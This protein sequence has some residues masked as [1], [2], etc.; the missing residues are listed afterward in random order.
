[1]APKPRKEST[2][3][4]IQTTTG[5]SSA[6]TLSM[7]DGEPLPE[8]EI[9]DAALAELEREVEAEFNRVMVENVGGG[10]QA[11]AADEQPAIVIVPSPHTMFFHP[12][13][14]HPVLKHVNQHGAQ[15]G[16]GTGHP[17]DQQGLQQGVHLDAGG[18][19]S[20]PAAPTA[21]AIPQG[22]Q[23]ALAAVPA[24]PAIP[25]GQQGV[26]LGAGGGVEEPAAPTAPAI[27]QAGQ[28]AAQQ[29]V[30]L[31]HGGQQGVQLQHGGQQGVQL[32]AAAGGVSEPAAP[33]APAIPQGQQGALAVPAA[34][35]IPQGQQGVQLGAGGGLSEP[36]ASTAPAIPQGQHGALA[37][38]A[39][40]AIPQGQ[41]GVQLGAGGGLSELAASTA[42]AIP[43]GQ[44]GVPAAPAIPQGQQLGQQGVQLGAGVSG[45]AGST[46][47][48]IPQGQHGAPAA[49]AAPAISQLPGLVNAAADQAAKAAE[50]ERKKSALVEAGQ[51]SS[52][53]HRA[54]YM[55]FLRAA[56]HPWGTQVKTNWPPKLFMYQPTSPTWPSIIAIIICNT[57][58]A[59]SNQ[60]QS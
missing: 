6:P 33:T 14:G 55:A 43:Q 16:S 23:G 27:S 30:Q 57:R 21:P 15:L 36:A 9:S 5:G 35:A 22:Q 46:A 2:K 19:V 32:G 4:D 54:E 25:Q 17:S 53:T 29:G 44:H 48:A 47:P 51:A 11:A 45:P 56:S 50:A 40:P 1:M 59:T 42:P 12:D 31:Q 49:P 8:D 10:V 24:A 38:P 7:A 60:P 34:P 18:G 39:A 28:Q 26:Q 20:G 3:A 52:T 41:Q 37:V 13:T 58:Y